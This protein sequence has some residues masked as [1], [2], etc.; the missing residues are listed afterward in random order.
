MY[1]LQAH[2]KR[3]SLITFLIA[4]SGVLLISDLGLRKITRH[5]ITTRL[6]HDADS[7][8][9]ALENPAGTWQLDPVR[10]STIYQRVFSG[11][12]YVVFNDQLEIRS[13]SLWDYTPMLSTLPP[14]A[15]ETYTT[16]GANHQQWLVQ[17]Q[18]INKD[19]HD[20]TIWV[21]EDITPLQ[22][23]LRQY[24]WGAL[25]LLGMALLFLLLVQQTLLSR[26]FARLDPIRERLKK[27]RLG[28]TTQ[29]LATDMPIEVTPLLD[30]I[31]HLL[32]QLAQRISRSRNALGNLAHELKRP[33]QRLRLAT[34][35]TPAANRDEQIELLNELQRLVERELKR[36]RIV[37]APSPGRQTV[38]ANELPPLREVLLKLYP[39]H[40]L[41]LDY[42]ANLILPQDRDDVLELLGNLL[43]NACRYGGTSIRLKIAEESQGYRI[44]VQD[45]GPGIAEAQL[46]Q[47]TQR[48]ERLDEKIAGSGLGLSI[49]KDIAASY[50][51]QLTL[52][53]V[54]PH[55]LVVDVFLRKDPN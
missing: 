7:L 17:S 48:G 36:A 27:I 39:Q 5:Y 55:G 37:G 1:S 35:Q 51:G 50:N 16:E 9:A 11:H 30:E 19:G 41:T 47:L 25:F 31:E 4:I 34:E 8:A 21:A 26:A 10:M 3:Y 38:L 24:R 52:H 54:A 13:R 29:D 18:G 14:G 44:K 49:S 6:Q 12:Y 20:I 40:D 22:N 45:D 32:A 33:M 46:N 23:T 2:I 28:E 53:S 42:P 15:S 43:D